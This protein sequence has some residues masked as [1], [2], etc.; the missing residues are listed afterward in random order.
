[1]KESAVKELAMNQSDT[2]RGA[3]SIKYQPRSKRYYFDA[4]NYGIRFA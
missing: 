1:M 4:A 3:P 2:N